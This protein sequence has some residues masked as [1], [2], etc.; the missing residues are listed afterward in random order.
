MREPRGKGKIERRRSRKTH[1]HFRRPVLRGR[2]S[3]VAQQAHPV[4]QRRCLFPPPDPGGPRPPEAQVLLES[5]LFA[6]GHP[7]TWVDHHAMR[8]EEVD[9]LFDQDECG[10]DGQGE[11]VGADDAGD[12]FEVTRG[13]VRLRRR[14]RSG[15]LS[16]LSQGKKEAEQTHQVVRLNSARLHLLANLRQLLLR[17]WLVVT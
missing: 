4:V 15:K 14:R 13:E 11:I 3:H 9:D 8:P 16:G 7:A 12:G 2:A 6:P 1:Q 17:L 5:V 10:I